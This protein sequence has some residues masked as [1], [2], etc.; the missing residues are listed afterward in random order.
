MLERAS[1]S[2]DSQCERFDLLLYQSEMRGVIYTWRL[3]AVK[4]VACSMVVKA[5]EEG[6]IKSQDLYHALTKRQWICNNIVWDGYSQ[7]PLTAPTDS[8]LHWRSA[9]K[10]GNQLSVEALSEA[11]EVRPPKPRRPH[12]PTP[13]APPPTL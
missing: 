6:N 13:A 3:H 11:L 7:R 1:Q 5:V 8:G 10:G 4:S 9:A 2:R 12:K